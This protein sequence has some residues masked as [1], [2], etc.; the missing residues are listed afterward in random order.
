MRAFQMTG[1]K[2]AVSLLSLE[3]AHYFKWTLEIDK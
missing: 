3:G 1:G 2:R